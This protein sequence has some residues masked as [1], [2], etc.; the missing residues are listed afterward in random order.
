MRRPLSCSIASKKLIETAF[1]Y[2]LF[3]RSRRNLFEDIEIEDRKVLRN[4]KNLNKHSNSKY[5]KPNTKKR[6]RRR[7]SVVDRLLL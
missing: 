3:R 4:T 2:N 5:L 1:N 6:K 7:H